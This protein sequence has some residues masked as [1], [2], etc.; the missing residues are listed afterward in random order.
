VIGPGDSRPTS[1]VI[2]GVPVARGSR[3][4]LRPRGRGDVFDLALAGRVAVV[5]GIEEDLEG[6]RH[7]AVTLADD[8][9]RDL[10]EAR[11]TGH[12]FFFAPDEVEPL[13]E[14]APDGGPGVRILVAGIGNVFLGDDGFGVEAVAR[15]ARR[16]LP[17]GVDV[18][19]FGIR[20]IDLAYAL[21]RGYDAAVLVDA[22]P[23]GGAPGTV[24]V[25]DAAGDELGAATV[26]T[27]AMDPVR[28]LRTAASMGPL[29]RRVLV[30]GCEPLTRMTGA[31]P[32]VVVALSA[33]VRDALE[34][35]VDTLVA[36]VEELAT[37]SVRGGEGR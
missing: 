32:D 27:H 11:Q 33:P 13:G 18:V 24:Y 19:D 16:P 31:E 5:E 8:P 23:R 29:P 28:V 22:T 4:R 25:I 17:A 36:L 2:D 20:G 34:P 9:G 21:G 1:V 26:E 15:L 14:A 12:R 35:A 6:T 30:V 37:T 10:G 7:V 3:V